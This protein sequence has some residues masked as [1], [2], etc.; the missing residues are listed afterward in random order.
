MKSWGRSWI[1]TWC[2]SRM[3]IRCNIP[4]CEDSDVSVEPNQKAYC[5]HQPGSKYQ[6]YDVGRCLHVISRI[7]CERREYQCVLFVRLGDES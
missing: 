5:W 1:S 4:S 7:G 6:I 2:R 3:E